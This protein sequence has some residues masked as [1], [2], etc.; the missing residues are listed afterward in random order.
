MQR[1]VRRAS[2]AA[3]TAAAI[4]ATTLTTAATDEVVRGPIA[5]SMEAYEVCGRVFPDPQA[6]WNPATE[7]DTPHP[8]VGV[9]PWAKGN[10]PCAARTFIS[11]D[12]ALRGLNFLANELE[13]TKDFIEV[14]DLANS[15]DPKI[16]EVLNEELGDGR[17]EGIPNEL[18][19]RESVPMYLIK[20]TAPEGA[21]LVD[22]VEPVA[23]EDR[24][25]FVWSLSMH[26]IERAGAEGGI[27]A[28]EDLA[29]WGSIEPDRRILETYP[30]DTITTQGGL[31][32]QNLR[33]G[34]VLMRSVSYFVLPNP[35]GW[36]RGDA[37][38]G[39]GG[40]MRYN[41][42]GMDLNRDF[43]E[44]GFTEPEFTPW[45]ET[46]SRTLG[47]VLQNVAERWT[48][49]IDLHGMVAANA[50]SYTLIGGS[51]RPFAKNERV[52]QFVEEAWADA[53]TRLAW[54]AQI[55]PNS[56]AD[57][58]VVFNGVT[59]SGAT[60]PPGD[61]DQRMYGVQYGTI[62]DTIDY[63]V[64]GAM[65]NWIDSPVGLNADGIDN[66]M[67]LS[68][69]GNCGT[70]TCYIP[71]AEQLHIDGN[72]GLIYAM[73]NFSLQPP[74]TAFEVG[75]DVAYLV[76]PRRLVDPGVA[77]PVAP[78][79]AQDAD[80]LVGSIEHVGGEAIL[81]EFTVD[82]ATG[83]E[84]VGG[85]KA[86]VRFSNAGSESP[87]GGASS[88]AVEYE[89]PDTGQWSNRPTYALDPVYRV[90]GG[91]AYW[92]YPEDGNYRFVLNSTV[93]QQ[94][95]WQVELTRDA[96]WEQPIQLPFD[97]TNMEFFDQLEP[98]LGEGT[99]LTAVTVDDV[100]SGARDLADFDTVVAVDDA[101]LP[102]YRDGD[103]TMSWG[104]EELP[105]T[106]WGDA[107][108][109]ELG[110]LLHAFAETGGNVVLTDD[111]VRGLAWM[112]IV[113]RDAITQHNVYAGHGNFN[114]G[115]G[116]GDPLAA[117]VSNPGSAQGLDQ[118]KQLVEPV[119]IGYDLNNSLPQWDVLAA[120]VA[121]AGGR[122]VATTNGD[123]STATIGEIPIGDGVVRWIGSILPYPT[124][125]YYHP[126]GMSSY[127]VTDN[128]WNML[129]NTWT[130][131]NPTQSAAPDLTDSEFAW[132][133][134][135]VPTRIYIDGTEWYADDA[136]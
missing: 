101:L 129:R 19:A 110:S 39:N 27:R 30:S 1:L 107:D 91:H 89:D 127:G 72:K 82:N 100:L 16:R 37:D 62:W 34:E 23:V 66:E 73:L 99:T 64:S 7:Q 29:T 43:P 104:K 54:S 47:H 112:G 26:G 98:S 90:P 108:A 130:W 86:T 135:D 18:G 87:A 103:E 122:V 5:D 77:T 125:G 58:C 10:L 92:N 31:E 20:V 93:P 102:G 2:Y 36:R 68:H 4:A 80:D 6:F 22:G 65:G 131:E 76:N 109:D 12:E 113:D 45:S 117:D 49:G 11:Y 57:Q 52:M 38:Q 42:N 71:E 126:F 33:V 9:S 44:I 3:V 15:T 121:D 81:A 41:G 105:S 134:S 40:F 96:A 25:H 21:V 119:P 94:V 59:P 24:E 118:R 88:V 97:V 69:L 116:Y 67:S 120:A 56:A 53:E 106:S 114:V 14:I 75:A 51:Q 83:P 35:D 128:G 70:G 50:F 95:W 84:Y 133:T 48:G 136:G 79:G 46:E 13:I 74:Q 124:S 111:A 78:E 123:A 63:T 17:T 55:K 28:I 60:N 8:G 85:I 115:E 132:I 61:C 32:A